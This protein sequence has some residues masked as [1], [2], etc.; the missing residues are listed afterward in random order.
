MDET[1]VTQHD[2]LSLITAV[3]VI[4]YVSP[5]FWVGVSIALACDLFRGLLNMRDKG[6]HREN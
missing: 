4:Y 3:G 6:T 5:D 2:I 1:K